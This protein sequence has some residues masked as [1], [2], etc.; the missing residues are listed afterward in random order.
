VSGIYRLRTYS[1]DGIRVW[2]DGRLVI[3]N[4]TVHAVTANTSPSI[5][6]A[7][8]T[9]H[10]IRVEYQENFGFAVAVLQWQVPG[11]S[12]FVAVPAN[13]LYGD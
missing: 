3:D 1:D 4:W 2:I 6:M 12:E 7:A 8:G 13:R 10:Q 9:R 11:S 5:T